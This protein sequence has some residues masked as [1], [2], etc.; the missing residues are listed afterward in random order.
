M[1]IDKINKAIDEADQTKSLPRK[2]ITVICCS[3]V[4]ICAAVIELRL[5]HQYWWGIGLFLVMILAPIGLL[6]SIIVD[7]SNL[8]GI[9]TCVKDNKTFLMRKGIAKKHKYK[10]RRL[11]KDERKTHSEM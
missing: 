3:L 10:W 4:L 7:S 11:T 9:A 5:F 1:E 6:I 8:I 2:M